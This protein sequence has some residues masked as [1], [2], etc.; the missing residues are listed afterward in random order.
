MGPRERQGNT[1]RGGGGNEAGRVK[2]LILKFK[3]PLR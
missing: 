2:Y 3:L 1:K